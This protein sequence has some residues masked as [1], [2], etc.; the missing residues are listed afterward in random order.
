M[1]YFG[2]VRHPLFAPGTMDPIY[3]FYPGSYPAP[4][5]PGFHP[6]GQ[7]LTLAERLAD[8]LLEAKYG[9]HRKQRRSRTAFTNQ[10]LSTLEKA[11]TKTHYPDV[12]MREKLAMCTNL[13]EARI[14]VWFKNRRAKYRKQQR[15]RCVDSNTEVKSDT[16][17]KTPQDDIDVESDDASEEEDIQTAVT[18]KEE[19]TSSNSIDE[20]QLPPKE[21]KSEIKKEEKEDQIDFSKERVE[22]R[23]R[24]LSN[25]DVTSDSE[26]DSEEPK[27]KLARTTSSASP[28]T[29]PPKPFSFLT[30][31]DRNVSFFGGNMFHG[32]QH[33][34]P[35][36]F[37]GFFLPPMPG[38]HPTMSP[39]KDGVIPPTTF[40]PYMTSL[41]NEFQ[42]T[43]IESLRLRARQH[44]A[45]MG[46]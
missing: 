45:T 15:N 14:Q 1:Q 3:G 39:G 16:E 25:G 13:P 9:A 32:Q 46:L 37:P 40:H 35:R 4:P 29:G 27:T 41:P 18:I 36:P 7:P 34:F 6:S 10:Q 12:V 2:Q 21:V 44:S 11:F 8:I 33:G 20:K 38:F 30:V 23:K 24:S 22:I 5:P 28:T 17:E 19:V 43:S 26:Q 42:H 31:P